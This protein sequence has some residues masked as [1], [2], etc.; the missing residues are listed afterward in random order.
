[1]IPITSYV[2]DKV[3]NMGKDEN[4][5]DG[6]EF[7]SPLSNIDTHNNRISVNQ[8]INTNDALGTTNTFYNIPEDPDSDTENS[9]VSLSS[10]T[11]YSK[12][13]NQGSVIENPEV[14]EMNNHLL[15]EEG[16]V[17][18]EEVGNNMKI[19]MHNPKGNQ[20]IIHAHIDLL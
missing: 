4:Q 9:E 12:M 7:T 13:C 5:P 10:D 16:E 20:S 3:N 14:Y 17:P 11:E 19:T 1:M 8:R 15:E 6:L 2:V 18:E